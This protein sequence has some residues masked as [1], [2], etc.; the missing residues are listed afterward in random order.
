MLAPTNEI[1][2]G[3]RVDICKA[4]SLHNNAYDPV[5]VHLMRAPVLQ[6]HFHDGDRGKQADSHARSHQDD[7]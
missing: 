3:Y 6:Q 4:S 2:L 7:R 5:I 1:N